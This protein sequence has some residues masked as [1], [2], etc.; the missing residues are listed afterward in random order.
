MALPERLAPAP[1]VGTHWPWHT[2]RW[3]ELPVSA[4]SGGERRLEAQVFLGSGYGVRLRIEAKPTGWKRLG[5]LAHV[6]QPAR[7]KGVL[8]SAEFG[9]P[10]LAASQVYR[11]RPRPRRWLA[12]QRIPD[13]VKRL[14]E[15]DTILVSRSG[16]VGRATIAGTFIEGMVVSDDLVRIRPKRPDWWGWTYAY[17]RSRSI[18]AVMKTAQYGHIVK[19]LETHHLEDLPVLEVNGAL[20]RSFRE[21]AEQIMKLRGDADRLM[22]DAE[23]LYEVAIGDARGRSDRPIGFVV[24]AQATFA[25]SRR[26][27]ANYFNPTAREAEEV[28]RSVPGGVQRLGNLVD[29]VFVPGRFKHVYGEGG[30]PYLDS[31]QVT[32]TTPDV[33][34]HVLSLRGSE[35]SDYL[36]E[37]GTLLMPCS[38]QLHGIIGT[39]H[40]A[41]SWHEG[42][43]LSNHILRI[44]P[45]AGSQ[46]RGGYL[47]IVLNHARL[48]R[49]R[50]IRNAFGSSVPEIAPDDIKRLTVP[51]LEPAVEGDIADRVEEATNLLKQATV[52]DEAT[53]EEAEH[54]VHALLD[55]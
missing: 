44:V 6:Y 37:R 13:Y 9:V 21:R 25:D 2:A 27:E 1:A 41:T 16:S 28:I 48:G 19:H 38:G 40:V 50:V 54:V 45:R 26:L 31:A 43:V 23:D 52:L 24:D 5:D 30:V 4:L 17:L 3:M 32:E 22:K 33:A 47:H 15:R 14:V 29:D 53:A 36:V 51:R 11:I 8:V 18:R 35:R 10:F 34:K 20:R 49:P 46:I 7:L 39:V 12:R 42:K 55:D